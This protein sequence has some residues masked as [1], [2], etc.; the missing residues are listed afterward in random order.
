[1]GVGT[2]EDKGIQP[3][4]FHHLSQCGES[5]DYHCFHPYL[6]FTDGKDTSFQN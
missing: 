6:L 4:P 2:G 3:F 1:M 5:L